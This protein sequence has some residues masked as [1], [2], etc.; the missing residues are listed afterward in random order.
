MYKIVEGE[1]PKLP[2]RYSKELDEILHQYVLLQHVYYKKKIDSFINRIL[3]R[4]IH[5]RPSASDV[6]Q[7]PF[8]SAQIERLKADLESSIATAVTQTV[9]SEQLEKEVRD[10]S[11]LM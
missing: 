8:I 9:S 2:E 5:K 6:L 7:V 3:S 11:D 4:D 10:I 1:I